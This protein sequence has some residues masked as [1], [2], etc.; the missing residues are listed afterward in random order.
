LWMLLSGSRADM[1]L[2]IGE[3]L[4]GY[5]QFMEFD[6]SELVLIE[7]LRSLRL[8]H[9]SAWLARRWDDPAFPMNFPWFNT[10]RYWEEQILNLREQRA[11]L[12]EPPLS[13][14]PD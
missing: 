8:M 1:E 4:A 2:Q 6:A 5:T 7:P 13:W 3:V 10:P 9:Y 11:L 14:R 12:D